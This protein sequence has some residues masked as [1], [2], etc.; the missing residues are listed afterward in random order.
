[1]PDDLPIKN[2]PLRP[3]Q[4]TKTIF[5]GMYEFPLNKLYT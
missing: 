5:E 3:I 4:K 2:K 1:M